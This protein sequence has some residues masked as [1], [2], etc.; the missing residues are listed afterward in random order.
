M[1]ATW[2][3]ESLG[4]QDGEIS[5]ALG[6]S[7]EITP[8]LSVGIESLHEIVLPEW[9]RQTGKQNFFLGPNLSLRGNGWFSTLIFLVQA[10][11]TADEPGAEARLIFGFDL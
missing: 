4:E 6:A 9:D 8:R 3:G 11:S 10:T 5:Q 2:S 7:Y 1:E